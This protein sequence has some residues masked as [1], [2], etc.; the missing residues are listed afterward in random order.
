[1]KGRLVLMAWEY[2]CARV[3]RVLAGIVRLTWL[4][5]CA[6]RCC[7]VPHKPGTEG[8]TRAGLQAVLSRC[9]CVCCVVLVATSLCGPDVC[10][11][12]EMMLVTVASPELL[13]VVADV[14]ATARILL[15][16]SLQVLDTRQTFLN[17]C[18]GNHYQFD[19]LRRGKHSSMMVGARCWPSH[20]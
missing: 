12:L 18:Q 6:K 10:T 19:M 5:G 1:M 14:A 3:F 2:V 8:Q 15:S 17:L 13:D 4:W 9:S 20:V 11:H 16:S 7:V